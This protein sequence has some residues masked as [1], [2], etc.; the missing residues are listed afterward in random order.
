MRPDFRLV[1]AIARGL[2]TASLLCHEEDRQLACPADDSLSDEGIVVSSP[3]GGRWSAIAACP[4]P[5]QPV[6]QPVAGP[7][8]DRL[9][10][11][12]RVRG[13]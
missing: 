7:V 13:A 11:R 4:A 5:L 6:D 10:S 1:N 12:R 3:P 9:C 8:R 2:V